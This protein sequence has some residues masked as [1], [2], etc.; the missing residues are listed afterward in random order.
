METKIEK[1]FIVYGN[2]RSGTK[3]TSC[4][5]KAHGLDV[6]HEHMGKDGICSLT[7]AT[8]ILPQQ[9]SFCNKK[10]KHLDTETVD[11]IKIKYNDECRKNY[12]FKHSLYIVR[13]PLGILGSINSL[14]GRD[15]DLR[16]KFVYVPDD[17]DKITKNAYTIIGW[18]ELIRKQKPDNIFKVEELEEKFPDY[19][20][21]L[22][23][24]NKML[25]ELPTKK[26]NSRVHVILNWRDLSGECYDM[27]Q[28]YAKRYG[29]NLED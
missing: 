7:F 3:Y 10:Y 22:G 9:C 28:E 27:M 2:G 12:S 29:Y 24:E 19:L 15:I 5:F 6:D 1:D 26:A 18:D 4:L 11:E 17:V 16:K 20:N 8:D 25:T 21:S 14:D 23:Y 13:H